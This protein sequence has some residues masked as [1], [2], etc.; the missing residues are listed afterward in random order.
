MARL[1]STQ[2]NAAVAAMFSSTTTFYLSLH[3]GD[4]STTGANEIA[5]GYTRQSITFSAPSAG[6]ATSFQ[7]Q[8]YTNIPAEASGISYFGIYSSSSAGTYEG[9]GTTSGLNGSIPSGA[10]VSFAAG[11]VSLSVS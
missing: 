5:S 11:G 7:S 2:E 1:P 8:N 3:T 4:P 10:T 6:L 9:G